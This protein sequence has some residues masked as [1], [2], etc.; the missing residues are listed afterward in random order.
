MSV[1]NFDLEDTYFVNKI[2][3]RYGF[4]SHKYKRPIRVPFDKQLLYL[5]LMS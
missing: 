5:K 3:S 2:L 1:G 4:V